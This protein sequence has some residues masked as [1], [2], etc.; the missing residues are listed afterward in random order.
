MKIFL[1]H[2]G[3][4]LR[5]YPQIRLNRGDEAWIR[6]VTMKQLGLDN[7]NQLRDRFEGQ[8]FFDRTMMN[9]GGLISIQ[10][11]LN[12]RIEDITKLDFSNFHPKLKIN[13][14]VVDV[15]VFKFG[16]LP[17]IDIDE[18]NN[19]TFFVIQKDRVTFNLCGFTTKEII[20][21]NMIRTHIERS[22]QANNM[23][24]IGFK[25]LS[26]PEDLL[27]HKL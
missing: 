23:N 16:T 11:H 10:K 7:L 17:L 1:N 26:N 5:T 20:K 9:V 18:I 19:T 6:D 4:F 25:S 22:S 24:F 3:E 12:L 14:E 13:D 27:K 15:Y 21:K 8:A 2:V